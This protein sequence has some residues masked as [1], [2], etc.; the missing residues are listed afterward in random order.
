MSRGTILNFSIV[1]YSSKQMFVVNV[2]MAVWLSVLMRVVSW[3]MLK[4]DM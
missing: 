1:A 4:R 2:T 3:E